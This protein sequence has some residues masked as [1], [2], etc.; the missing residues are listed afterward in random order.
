MKSSFGRASFE[1]LALAVFIAAPASIA[2]P[3]PSKEYVRLGERVIAIENPP[4]TVTVSPAAAT[5]A[6][7]GDSGSFTVN[8]ARGV[9]WTATSS[10]SSWLTL[11]GGASQISGTGAGSVT[12]TAAANQTNQQRS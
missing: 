5:A 7:A 10:D 8:A 9:S 3:S 2:Q 12:W 6:A 4:A 11:T 1:A